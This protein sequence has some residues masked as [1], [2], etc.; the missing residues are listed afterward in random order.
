MK[1]DDQA[2]SMTC[3]DCGAYVEETIGGIAIC[4]ACYAAR[5]S[6]CPE[7]G[8]FD[9]TADDASREYASPPCFAHLFEDADTNTVRHDVATQRFH[10]VHGARLDYRLDDRTLDITHTFV[11]EHLRGKGVAAGL[12]DA[13]IDYAKRE[14]LG[15]HASC[16]YAQVYLKRKGIH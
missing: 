1:P 7:F 10:Y 4:D 16:D 6:C 3:I 2:A 8:A 5:G 15:L 11:P 14:Q 12:M 13:V 9:L